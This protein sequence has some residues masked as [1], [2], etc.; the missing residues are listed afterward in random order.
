[1]D[2]KRAGIETVKFAATAAFFFGAGALSGKILGASPSKVGL[3]SVVALAAQKIFDS[4]NCYLAKKFD[5]NLSNYQ[6]SKTL[7]HVLIGAATIVSLF[8]LGIIGPV[9][10]GVMA[11]FLGLGFAIDLG[12]AIY[13]KETDKDLTMQE[14]KN[15]NLN[16]LNFF[17]NYARA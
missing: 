3:A 17:Q 15:T 8:A 11:G 5:W 7:G 1:M 2:I 10:A 13:L 16:E 9:G 4:A 12:V 6:I 14:A